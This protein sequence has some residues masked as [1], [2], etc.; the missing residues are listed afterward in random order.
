MAIVARRGCFVMRALFVT[1]TV[2]DHREIPEFVDEV[3]R[4][5]NYLYIFRRRY[6]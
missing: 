1:V 4:T 2:N 6:A 5:Q 3:L